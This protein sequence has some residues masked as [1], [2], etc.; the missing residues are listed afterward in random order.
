MKGTHIKFWQEK[1]TLDIQVQYVMNTYVRCDVC[2][3]CDELL[4]SEKC[5]CD[6]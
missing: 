3:Q 5:N 6:V 4:G 2:D 1:L